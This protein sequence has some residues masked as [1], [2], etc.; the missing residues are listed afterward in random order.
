MYL[1]HYGELYY[2]EQSICGLQ[3]EHIV[4]HEKL[5]TEIY[6]SW[7]FSKTNI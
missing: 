7:L 6:E 4:K 3:D 2:I 1:S 5:N